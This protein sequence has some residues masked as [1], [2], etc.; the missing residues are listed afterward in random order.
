VSSKLE[1]LREL[2]I[3]LLAEEVRQ[4]RAEADIAEFDR[5]R[6]SDE[7]RDRAVKPGR[8]RHLYINDVVTG[9]SVDTWLDV[10]NHWERRDPG[11][12]IEITIN[13][14][15]GS[16]LDGLALYDAIL[17]LRRKGHHVTTRGT[18]LI[19]SMAT[20][21]MQAGDERIL[22][23]N[24]WFMIHEVSAGSRG[25]VSEMEDQAAFV[26]RLNGRLMDILAER[27]TLTKKQILARTKKKDDW[28]SADEAVGFG[29]ADKVE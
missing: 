15:G 2:K 20:I 23:A 24:S 29:F 16:V 26:K 14:P 28:L 9:R 1:N 11:E 25:T 7:E 22:D 3:Q 5:N 19:A 21:L 13:S 10:L 12:P 4:A 27:S 8:I 18:G 17:R 6:R